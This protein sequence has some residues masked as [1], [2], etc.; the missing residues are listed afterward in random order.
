M[1]FTWST[2]HFYV[3]H[4]EGPGNRW[5]ATTDSRAGLGEECATARPVSYRCLSSIMSPTDPY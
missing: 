2:G 3:L 5:E 1:M 4:P